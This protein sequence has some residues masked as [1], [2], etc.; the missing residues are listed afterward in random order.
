MFDP[1]VQE[2]REIRNSHA[3]KFDYDLSK[4]VADYQKKHKSYVEKL[5]SINKKTL[6]VESITMKT[7]KQPRD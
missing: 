7:T 6:S 5:A 4:I 1:I 2:I 3:K